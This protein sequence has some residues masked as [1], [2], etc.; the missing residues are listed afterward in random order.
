M[1]ASPTDSRKKICIGYHYIKVRDSAGGIPRYVERITKEE[2]ED[3][4]NF[5]NLASCT[6]YRR[7]L[8]SRVFSIISVLLGFNVS[9]SGVDVYWGPAHRLPLFRLK[10]VRYIVTIHDL[11][12]KVCPQ[13]MPLRRRLAESILFPLALRNADIILAVS[14]NTAKDIVHYFPS[15]ASKV[16]TIPL[17]AGIA[18]YKG[19]AVLNKRDLTYILFVG[20][21][22][23]RKNIRNMLQAYSRLSESLKEKYKFIIVGNAGWGGINIEDL[24]VE[25]DLIRF[26]KWKRSVGDDELRELYRNAYCLLFVSYYEGFGLPILEA[27]CF[28]VP[29]ITSNTSSL[30]EVAGDGALLVDPH[31]VESITASLEEL[32]N[33]SSL[34]ASLSTKAYLNSEKYSWL[35]TANKTKLVFSSSISTQQ[36]S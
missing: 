13:T 9:G 12:W 2:I 17:A 34:R 33:N 35:E 5:Q 22:E 28:G 8:L 15:Y 32:L 25:F 24:L 3:G 30:P 6:F 23:P 14:Q 10:S 20:T 16:K 4:I 36:Q 21:I 31:S 18:P 11:V 27:Q 29:V 7:S 1:A 26:V 19:E